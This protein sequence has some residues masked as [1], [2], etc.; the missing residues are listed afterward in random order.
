VLLAA[1]SHK[2]IEAFHRYFAGD[3]KLRLPPVYLYKGRVAR[4]V[5]HRFHIGAITF[6]RHVFVKP[7]LIKQN[8]EGRW[9]VPAW[10]VAHE[11]THVLQYEAA[12]FVGFLASYL[13]DYWRS[14]RRQE[15]WNAAARMAAYFAIEVECAA[16]EAESAYAAWKSRDEG[17]GMRDEGVAIQLE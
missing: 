16:R 15:K 13:R 10:L 2:H 9:T 5:T 1:D 8:E 12:G 14:L 6:G 17:R 3:E 7:E 11:T 4:W